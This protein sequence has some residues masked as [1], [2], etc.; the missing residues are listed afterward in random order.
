[1]QLS[2][3]H[4]SNV[5]V[6]PF[7]LGALFGDIALPARANLVVWQN[8]AGGSASV[9]SNWSPAVIPMASYEL[10]FL[11]PDTYGVFFD[12]T[13]SRSLRHRYATGN[14]TLNI[15]SLHS[16]QHE[17]SVASGN[18][19][20]ASG[21]LTT[22][23]W[24]E[25]GR[26]IGA[27]AALNVVQEGHLSILST[28]GGYLSVGELGPGALNILDGGTVDAGRFVTSSLLSTSSVVVSGFL[29]SQRRPSSLNIWGTSFTT[30]IG[31]QHPGLLTVSNGGVASFAGDANIAERSTGQATVT[32][33]GPG[34]PAS[35]GVG[36]NL[37]VAI[38]TTSEAGGTA[39]IDVEAN[40]M[41]DVVGAMDLG[42]DAQ[43][44][45]ATLHVAHGGRVASGPMLCGL[46]GHIRLDGGVVRS[47]LLQINGGALNGH[48]TISA[49]V[50]M[51][52]GTIAPAGDSAS[53]GGI[54]AVDGAFTMNGAAEFDVDIS[55]AQ[56]GAYDK[57]N[58]TGEALL[59]GTLRIRLQDGFVPPPNRSIELIS[60]GSRA[61]M[62]D[63]VIYSGPPCRDAVVEYT[64]TG[65]RVRFVEA[66][67]PGDVSPSLVGDAV[68]NVNDL[69]LVILSWGACPAPPAFCPADTD[70]SG[71]VDVDDL[72][73]VITHWGACP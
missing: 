63:T 3:L 31:S 39:T 56:P 49:S 30:K 33:G 13:T 34:A 48:G 71:S 26:T 5:R 15:D 2:K 4:S 72:L 45:S 68:I 58:I 52:G 67:C 25:I 7:L 40:G 55:G 6:L 22:D 14:I 11:L 27:A 8:P 41:V 54:L 51:D 53:D 69:L 19:T 35:V 38:N 65:A 64:R 59:A 61:G 21:A 73:A 1:M 24:V 37:R 36:G 16:V 28:S 9:A 62:F 32:V 20:L 44:G 18:L 10:Y 43:G 50:A 46:N 17:I 12:S 60:A 70:C 66:A 47:S 57:I 42:T 23:N 29:D